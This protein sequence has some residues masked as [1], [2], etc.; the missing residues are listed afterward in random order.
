MNPGT[1]TFYSALKRM[2]SD[3]LVHET[4]APTGV[5]STD[6]RRRY[7]AVTDLGRRVLQAETERLASILS[8]ARSLDVIPTEGL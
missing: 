3:G 8:T 7:Y 6:R 4:T 1:G 2:L 5:T